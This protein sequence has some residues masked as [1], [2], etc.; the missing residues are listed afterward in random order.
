MVDTVPWFRQGAPA[1][2]LACLDA[3]R[4]AVWSNSVCSIDYQRG[5]GVRKRYRVEPYSLAA[6]VDLWYLVGQTKD[7]MRVFRLSRILRLEVTDNV[8][9]RDP[10]FDLRRFW[11]RW[12]RRFESEPLSSYWVT[13]SLTHAGRDRLLE[14]YGGWHARALDRWDEARVH[15]VVRLDLENEEMAVR[16]LFDLGGEARVVE[17]ER[18]RRAVRARALAVAEGA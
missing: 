10:D 15:N 14:R 1:A 8:Y 12:C 9:V 6:K 4:R 7:G 17:P 5:D 2:A 11:K 13:L 18:L 16:I 3:L